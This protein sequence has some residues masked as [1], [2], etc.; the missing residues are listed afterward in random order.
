MQSILRPSISCSL[1]EIVF[2]SQGFKHL[3]IHVHMP[4][5]SL[6]KTSFTVFAEDCRVYCSVFDS[7]KPTE[8]LTAKDL[9]SGLHRLPTLLG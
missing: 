7:L 6:Q 3:R 4:L 1:D 8:S 2:S 5:P 9:R